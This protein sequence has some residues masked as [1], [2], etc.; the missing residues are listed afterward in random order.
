[1]KIFR[2]NKSLY[3]FYGIFFGLLFPLFSI[4]FDSLRIYHNIT[5][6][7]IYKIHLQNPLHFAIDSTPFLL[8]FFARIVGKK[9]DRL[10][11]N[12]CK[13]Q[14]LNKKIA[15]EI[16]KHEKIE[17]KLR[18]KNFIIEEDLDA[19]K[20]IQQTFLPEIPEYEPVKIEYRYLP[21]MAVGGDF[22]SLTKFQEGGLG[23][24][25]GDVSGH[26]ISAALIT[27][28]IRA[29]S[30]KTCRYF[31]QDPK[32][33]LKRLNNELINLIPDNK[34]LT[35]IYGLLEKAHDDGMKFTFSR[36][37]HPYPIIWK[38]KDNQT[39]MIKSEGIPIGVFENTEFNNKSI[40]V[41]AGDRIFLYTDG[42]IEKRNYSGEILNLEGLQSLIASINKKKLPL[43]ETLDSIIKEVDL[44]SDERPPSDDRV[45]LG[46]EVL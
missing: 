37:A 22:L 1:M 18:D 30:N 11:E 12:C 4:I 13:L 31:G 15:A 20:L 7:I 42:I 23:I 2:R 9:Q 46:I 41:H 43:G 25:L 27:S 44:F 26:G 3:T 34:Y 33:F 5:F 10:N 24:F 16:K 35:A 36:G 40:D 39:I 8:G 28:L 17:E 32:E 19:A 45:L 6:E 38:K 29:I 14:I 21:M